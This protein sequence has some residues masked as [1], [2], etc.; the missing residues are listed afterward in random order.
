[1]VALNSQKL[2]AHSH[3]QILYSTSFT[4]QI[5][6]SAVFAVLAFAAAAAAVPT[7][8]LEGLAV[9]ECKP[10]LQSCSVDS[11]CCSDGC[12]LGVSQVEFTFPTQRIDSIVNSFASWL[13]HGF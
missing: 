10:L 7:P 1:M 5:F 12:L 8:E 2:S 6:K 11:D 9:R 13:K 3:S 4:M